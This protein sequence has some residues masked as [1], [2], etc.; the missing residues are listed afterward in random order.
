MRELSLGFSSCPND[1]YIFEALAHGKIDC[2]F[3]FAT[4]IEDIDTLNDM[5]LN[6]V[7]DV[8]KVSFHALF[9]VLDR[10][11]LSSSGAALG[12][13]CGPLLV[14]KR[15][16]SLASGTIALPGRLTT[17]DMLFRIALPD[18]FRR[19]YMRFDK[20]V[21]AILAGE[22][23]AGVIIHESR[24]TYRKAGLELVLDL[25]RWWEE[26]T[27]CLIPLGG[28]AIAKRIGNEARAEVERSIK[29]S[30]EYAESHPASAREFIR[31]NAQEL[32]ERVIDEHIALYVNR[33]SK[34]LGEEGR[35]AAREL[36]R[37]GRELDLL[38]ESRS[39]EIGGVE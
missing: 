13:G 4:G 36:Y 7:L 34:D 8:S 9:H 33:F 2:G 10:Y 15:K 21:P 35:K 37:R 14:A 23:D 18:D 28:V 32:D 20:I 29:A 26:E 19:S 3:K 27:G 12:K 22:V 31:D 24:F 17:A 5:A 6:G 1:T 39:F 30:I 11:A 25:G 38:P 16:T